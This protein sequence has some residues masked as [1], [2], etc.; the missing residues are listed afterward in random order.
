MAKLEKK[1]VFMAR[2]RALGHTEDRVQAI[3]KA[4]YA[5]KVPAKAAP[6]KSEA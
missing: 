1:E 4:K 2:L 6:A 3:I 5:K